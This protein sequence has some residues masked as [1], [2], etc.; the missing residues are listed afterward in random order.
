MRILVVERHPHTFNEEFKVA[1][2]LLFGDSAAHD[3][4]SERHHS[5]IITSAAVYCCDDRPVPLT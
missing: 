3:V 2:C 4:G 1:V 5:F